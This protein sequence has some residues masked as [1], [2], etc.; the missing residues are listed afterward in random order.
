MIRILIVDDHALMREGLKQLIALCPDFCVAGESGDGVELLETLRQGSAID[1]VL[2]DM[3]MP[4]ID[5]VDLISHI[6]T[7]YLQVPILVLSMHNV[8]Q[9]ARHA[10]NAGASGYLTKD[11][12]PETLIE[13]IRMVASGNH[14]IDP[15]L[16]EMMASGS[17]D[18]NQY[19]PHK[20][21]SD[22]ELHILL[23]LVKGM[24][25]KAVA[26]ELSISSKTVSTHK[27][28]LM[29]KLNCSSNTE[30]IRYGIDHGLVL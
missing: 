13:A 29:R 12:D 21:L 8:P 3:S 14:Y 9:I 2:L 24:S 19:Q 20:L 27:A 30:M 26:E 6:R 18:A 25:I 10:L 16:A 23:L 7:Y 22:R 1:L 28:R 11:N 17:N 4:G 15:K 5:G